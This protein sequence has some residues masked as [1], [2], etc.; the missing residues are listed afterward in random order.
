MYKLEAFEKTRPILVKADN[1]ILWDAASDGQRISTNYTRV[2]LFEV[3]F[4]FL[5][6]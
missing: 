4:E 6:G 5:I 3:L 2:Y 1:Q